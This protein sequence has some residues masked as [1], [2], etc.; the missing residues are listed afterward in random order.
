MYFAYERLPLLRPRVSIPYNTIAPASDA[1]EEPR[2]NRRKFL[3]TVVSLAIST[4][5]V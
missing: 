3:T 4:V 1:A 5:R 2:E